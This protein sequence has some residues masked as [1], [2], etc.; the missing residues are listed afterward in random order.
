MATRACLRDTVRPNDSVMS[1]ALGSSPRGRD[2]SKACTSVA[3]VRSTMM[4]PR[5]MPGHPRRPAP[6]GSRRKSVP[7][8]SMFA[9]RPAMKRSGSNT[10]ARSHTL[11][12]RPIA[13]MF[14]YR[15][16]PAGISYPAAMPYCCCGRY[17][18]K[19]K[20]IKCSNADM[21]NSVVS[22]CNHTCHYAVA[23]GLVRHQQWPDGMHAERL[24][25][26]SLQVAQARDVRFLHEPVFADHGVELC[27]QL[28]HALR[29]TQ[30]LRHCPLDRHGRGVCA[31]REHVLHAPTINL[32]V[33]NHL[34]VN[35]DMQVDRDLGT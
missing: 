27:L 13:Y 17:H 35:P 25:D 2:Q 3:V 22:V 18:N 21:V 20:E 33:V 10:S 4:R 29:V 11:S 32:F 24:L 30:K 16:V 8:R 34:L 6:N 9:S 23:N 14:T 12:S 31:A 7:L 5:A 26:H 1:R 19:W 15:R 28:R